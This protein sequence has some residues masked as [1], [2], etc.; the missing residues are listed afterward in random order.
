MLPQKRKRDNRVRCPG[1]LAWIR[2][3]ACSVGGCNKEP[4]VAAHARNG[5]DGGASLKPGDNWTISLCDEHH[6]HQHAI[7]E[8]SFR[9]LT[10]V[11]MKALAEEFWRKSPHRLTYERKRK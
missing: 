8:E 4:I 11:D 2:Q 1:H 9:R 3:H 7:G 10:G 6:R 5:T